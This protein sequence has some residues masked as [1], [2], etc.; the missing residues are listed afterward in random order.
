MSKRR[1]VSTRHFDPDLGDRGLGTLTMLKEI[2]YSIGTG[3][4][5]YYPGSA[6][7]GPSF[8]DY[9]KRFA[10]LE[11]FDWRGNWVNYVT[12]S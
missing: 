8:Y 2:E 6:Y 11:C 4:E 12:T 3:R 5:Y 1:R 9:K 7:E 10:A